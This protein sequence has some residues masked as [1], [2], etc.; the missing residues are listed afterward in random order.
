[1]SALTRFIGRLFGGDDKPAEK[2]ARQHVPTRRSSYDAAQTGDENR[3]HWK[4][5]DYLSANAANSTVVRG[6]LRV[7]SRYEVANNGYAKGLVKS[8]TNDTIGTGPRLQ[9][10]FPDQV[11]DPD[12][13]RPVA[14]GDPGPPPQTSADLARIVERRWYEWCE[15]VGLSDKLRVMADA[16]DV[17]GEAFGL[18]INRDTDFPV[19]LGIRLLEADRVTTPDLYEPTEF[20]IDGIQFNKSGDPIFYDVLRQHPGDTLFTASMP[21]DYDTYPARQ[22]IHLFDA[23]RPEQGR[24][25][26]ILT[27]ALPLYSIL[28]RYTLASLGSAEIAAMIAGVIESQNLAP[29]ATGDDAPEFEAMDAIPFARNALLTM[30]GGA[31]AKKFDSNTP[32]QDYGEFKAEV[33]TEAGRAAGEMR[34]TATGSSAAYNYSSG[35]LDHL[36][37][38]RA[39]EIRVRRI[40]RQGIDRIFVAWYSEAVA[41]PGYLPA[42]LPPTEEWEWRWQWDGFPSIDPEKDAKAAEIE[43]RIG[44]TTDSILLAKRGLDWREVYRQLAREKAMRAELGIEPTPAPASVAATAAVD[45]ED[46]EKEDD[47]EDETEDEEE[48][49]NG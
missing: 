47:T 36:P 19:K 8:R 15:E 49:A 13:Q 29:D 23:D 3:N 20:K 9:L 27:P 17:D 21:W 11:Y 44:L 35:R 34:N 45:P 6:I 7:R 48:T 38:Q 39:L 5:A 33:L 43:K 26:P 2:P 12:F 25:I 46:E 42:G 24:G 28:R 18:F 4:A 22:V 1:M 37:R 30:P 16:E 41:I 14:V 40:E 10:D 31:T 32:T